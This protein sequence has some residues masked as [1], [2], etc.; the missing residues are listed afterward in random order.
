MMM[1]DTTYAARLHVVRRQDS[2]GK[3]TNH[4]HVLRRQSSSGGDQINHIHVV[5]RGHSSSGGEN[6]HKGEGYIGDSKEV[7]QRY[8]EN[9]ENNGY[10]YGKCIAVCVN[11]FP[12]QDPNLGDVCARRCKTQCHGH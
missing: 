8:G 2:S 10:C 5:R 9:Q 12:H 7:A 6:N 1:M 11:P 3:N 4:I